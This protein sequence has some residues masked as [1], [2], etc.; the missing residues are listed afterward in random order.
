MYRVRSSFSLYNPD[1][2]FLSI[3]LI[4]MAAIL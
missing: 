2:L 3:T 1:L 4:G